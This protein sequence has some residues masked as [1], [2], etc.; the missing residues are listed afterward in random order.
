[1]P[2]GLFAPEEG[3]PRQKKKKEHPH[4]K[5]ATGKKKKKKQTRMRK[6]REKKPV[7]LLRVLN[8]GRR[9]GGLSQQAPCESQSTG[10]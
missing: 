10:T 3:E 7:E 2:K 1:V 8:R 9:R 5:D 4:Q 6:E